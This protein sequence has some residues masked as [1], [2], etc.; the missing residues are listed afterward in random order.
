[1]RY[2]VSYGPDD[3]YNRWGHLV[4]AA[5]VSSKYFDTSSKAEEVAKELTIKY[6]N[7]TANVFDMEGPQ[8]DPEDSQSRLWLICSYKRGKKIDN[9]EYIKALFKTNNN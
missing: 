9:T 2:K 6:K 3:K 8:E 1:M 5:P 4:K 7:W